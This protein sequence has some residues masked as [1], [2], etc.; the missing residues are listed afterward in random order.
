[1]KHEILKPKQRD[2][3][4]WLLGD[5]RYWMAIHINAPENIERIRWTCINGIYEVGTKQLL[6][7]LLIRFNENEEAKKD[8]RNFQKY[9]TM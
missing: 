8:W 1:M 5:G 4:E 7:F 6:N 2:W 3:L 9:K